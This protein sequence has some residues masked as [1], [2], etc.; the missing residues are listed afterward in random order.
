MSKFLGDTLRRVRTG[1]GVAASPLGTIDFIADIDEILATAA[2]FGEEDGDG[3]ADAIGEDALVAAMKWRVCAYLRD[4]T[5]A[6][7]SAL[8]TGLSPWE[9]WNDSQVFAFADAGRAFTELVVV[10]TSQARIETAPPSLVPV[11]SSMCRLYAL[12]CVQRDATVFLEGEY[13]T[14]GQVW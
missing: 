9:A 2:A 5:D 13:F 4:A 3:Q 12:K 11:L 8:S 14:P 7:L 6:I 10:Q 1:S